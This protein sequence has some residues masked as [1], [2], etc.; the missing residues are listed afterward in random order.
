MARPLTSPVLAGAGWLGVG[1]LDAG[2]RPRPAACDRVDTRA[3]AAGCPWRRRGDCFHGHHRFGRPATGPERVRQPGQ[4]AVPARGNGLRRGVV[5]LRPRWLAGHL[6]GE[7]QQPRPESPGHPAC[8]FPVSQQPR[9]HIHRCHE[10]GG[11]DSLRLG[12]GVLR[13]RLRQRRVRRS[14]RH[15]LGTERALPQQRRRDVY[16]RVGK[17]RR[18]GIGDPLGRRL[19]FSGL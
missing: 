14:V 12:A 4:Q 9:R 19:L 11:V 18:R 3:C 1:D 16:E 2:T 5:R 7:R 8:Q 6:S 17:G 10:E 13:R 15:V